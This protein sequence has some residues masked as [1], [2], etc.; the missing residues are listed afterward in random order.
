MPVLERSTLVLWMPP[1][2]NDE[3]HL[4]ALLRRLP[5]GRY[6]ELQCDYGL[7]T[8]LERGSYLVVAAGTDRE[9]AGS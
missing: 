8:V 3:Q 1:E 7:S 9:R 6:E 2:I 5:G 4:Y